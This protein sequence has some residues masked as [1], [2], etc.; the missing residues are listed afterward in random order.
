MILRLKRSKTDTDDI[1]VE[2]VLAATHDQ[3]CPVAALRAL[4]NQDPQPRTAPLF[5]PTGRSTAFD[6]TPVISILQK[7]LQVNNIHM[8]KSYTGHS[9]RK[10][11]A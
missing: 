10:G 2:I 3:T 11:A 6:R 4:F 8:P 5:R 9:F 7:R 1:G